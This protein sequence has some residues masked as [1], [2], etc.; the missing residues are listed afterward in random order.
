MGKCGGLV[1]ESAE[2]RQDCFKLGHDD[3]ESPTL[4]TK[5]V[6]RAATRHSRKASLPA[7]PLT[8]RGKADRAELL[9]LLEKES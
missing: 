5:H 3:A 4:A 9:R 6:K 8:A 1:L 2:K 7:F